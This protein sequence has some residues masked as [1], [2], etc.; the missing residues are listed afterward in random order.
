MFFLWL[1]RGV[2]LIGVSVMVV[3]LILMADVSNFSVC[4]AW[5]SS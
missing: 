2:E 3:R 4:W 1:F 5:Q